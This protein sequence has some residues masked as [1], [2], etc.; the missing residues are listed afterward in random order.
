MAATAF[1]RAGGRMVVGLANRRGM[2]DAARIGE[3]ELCASGLE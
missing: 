3:G 1:N 2:G